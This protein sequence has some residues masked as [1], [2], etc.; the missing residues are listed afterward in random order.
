[1]RARLFPCLSLSSLALS[2]SLGACSQGE[3]SCIPTGT[4]GQ[5]VITGGSSSTGGE[6]GNDGGQGGD[7][8]GGKSNGGSGG[9]PSGGAASGG[10]ASLPER[11]PGSDGYNCDP[12][13]GEIPLL[14]LTPV[15]VELH[16]PVFVT[17]AP[18]DSRLFILQL[19]GKIRI[20]QGDTLK[21]E[22]FLDLG[23]KVQVGGE[24]GDE[25]GLLGIAFA[26]DYAESGLFYIHYSS[27]PGLEAQYE[28]G[29]TIIEEYRVSPDPDRADSSTARVVFSYPQ[30]ANNH[31]GGS[32]NFGLDGFL[33]IGLGDGGGS[34][35]TYENGQDEST[36][37]GAILRIDPRENGAQA[38]T[39]PPG[40]LVEDVP[41]AAPEIW[42]MGL[43]NPF[44]WTFDAC[45][46][47]MYVGDVGQ[48]S[49]E[50][51]DIELALDG[52]RNYGWNLMEGFSCYEAEDC[53]QTGLTLPMLDYPNE[54]SA[55]SVTGGSVYRGS[56]IPALRGAYFYADYPSNRVW[57][58]IFD[59]NEQK[60]SNPISY[61]Q[62]LTL[63][64]PVAI[65]TG[66]D[67]ELYFVSIG[68]GTV[69][70]LDPA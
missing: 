29:D 13:E 37:L 19:D 10:A 36:P 9:G 67:G 38:Y 43:R 3:T 69:H 48:G 35:D 68:S 65:Q 41:G 5:A 21:T 34:G 23:D 27:G 45:T 60:V 49:F 39:V 18:N 31:N 20:V 63:S 33:Y 4:G 26:P 70:R 59:R 40:N 14:K 53:D 50:E 47:D 52:R 7:A 54:G 32:I 6:T 66:S 17:H 64:G 46:G 1:M 11:I 8:S 16:L 58:V 44:R 57:S 28:I 42:D 12:P 2:F 25:R 62:D 51:I 56:K 22:P 30:P 61:T 15:A 24:G 55:V